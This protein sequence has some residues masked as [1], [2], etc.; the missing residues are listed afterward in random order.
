[1]H[2]DMSVTDGDASVSP[3][4]QI[5]NTCDAETA[6]SLTCGCSLVCCATCFKTWV[7]CQRS[8]LCMCGKK[9]VT[10]L[11]L[12]KFPDILAIVNTL[13]FWKK[14]NHFKGRPY[15]FTVV[16]C[17]NIVEKNGTCAVCSKM[18]CSQC[19]RHSMPNAANS[20]DNGNLCNNPHR[21][22]CKVYASLRNCPQCLAY[23]EKR[24][25]CDEM[26]CSSCFTSFNYSTG[27][28]L[29]KIAQDSL[30]LSHFNKQGLVNAFKYSPA[31]SYTIVPLINAL[32]F[33]MYHYVSLPTSTFNEW[34]YYMDLM[35]LMEETLMT[36]LKLVKEASLLLNAIPART[37]K[38]FAHLDT[39]SKVLFQDTSAQVY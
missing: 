6:D 8:T 5:C 11:K 18:T 16:C 4:N 7:E 33:E 35:R 12:H 25:G 37:L 3:T 39:L 28:I 30:K 32:V 27:A 23:M 17:G 2:S 19:L 9:Y 15:A 26:F 31:F 29:N 24:D 36:E 20:F 10:Y 38:V 1:M 13:I 21:C 14:S 22:G 34:S